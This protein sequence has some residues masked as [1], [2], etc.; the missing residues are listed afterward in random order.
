[1]PQF[2][3]SGAVD[4]TEMPRRIPPCLA[5]VMPCYNE[6][7]ILPRT[8]SRIAGFLSAVMADESVGEC[9]FVLC[10]DDGS[11][12]ATW[13][14]ITQAAK[15]DSRIRGI[16]LSR[17]CGHQT[18]LLAGLSAVPDCDVV[19]SIDADL[20][21]DPSAIRAMLA[22]WR[23]GFGVVYGVRD[24]RMT[25]TLFKR[26]TAGLFYRLMRLAGVELI[27]DHADFRL[28]DRAALDAL[29]EYRER[30]LFLRGLVPLVGFRSTIVRYARLARS[31]GES[32][33]P[34]HRMIALAV[35][36]ITSFSITP[37]RMIALAGLMI[38]CLSAVAVLYALAVKTSGYSIR[39]WT[40]VIIAIFF[41]G[42]V[43]M[44]SLGIIGEYIGKIYL[45]TKR[46][47]HFHI[48]SAVNTADRS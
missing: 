38:S 10:V 21:D 4:N 2:H 36:G 8:V 11:V 46:R 15:R 1:M 42:G 35:E 28:L 19:V 31:A 30:N 5:I 7:S 20:Q 47:P 9:S 24:C 29:L 33:Y 43:Q 37:L 17:N 48:A 23:A 6:E 25:D 41:M 13:E 40:S 26:K 34:L 16:R 22:A 45:E 32:K 12:D 27:L 18:A 44:L 39:G 14:L 3:A